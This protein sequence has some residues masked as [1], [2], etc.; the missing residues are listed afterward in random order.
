MQW[1]S[2]SVKLT[3]HNIIVGHH[4]EA[5]LFSVTSREWRFSLC[6]SPSSSFSVLLS[7]AVVQVTSPMNR[8]STGDSGSRDQMQT[9]FPDSRF[10]KKQPRPFYRACWLKVFHNSI[11]AFSNMKHKTK[12]IFTMAFKY[13]KSIEL[14]C[15]NV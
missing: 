15:K 13:F 2:L 3:L 11:D 12:S 10:N 5:E 4:V 9:G 1:L 6:G 7:L 14:N 8:C